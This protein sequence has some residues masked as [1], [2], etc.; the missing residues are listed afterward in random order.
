[1]QAYKLNQQMTTDPEAA[2]PDVEAQKK[3]R[4]LLCSLHA[5]L[6][7]LKDCEH[8]K[9]RTFLGMR[10]GGIIR[11]SLE[12][13]RR[14]K[15]TNCSRFVRLLHLL[16]MHGWLLP[17]D[18][19]LLLLLISPHSCGKRHGMASQLFQLGVLRKNTWVGRAL[20]LQNEPVRCGFKGAFATVLLF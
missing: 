7:T 6:T 17:R 13:L 1:M 9:P 10:G 20:G 15:L 12:P 8:K 18:R 14:R 19:R 16:R 5:L 3:A 4:V 2:K 11:E